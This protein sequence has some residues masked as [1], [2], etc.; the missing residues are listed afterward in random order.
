MIW[1]ISWISILYLMDDLLGPIL[2]IPVN[3]CPVAMQQSA[4]SF[5]KFIW[6]WLQSMIGLT[7][8]AERGKGEEQRLLM[9]NLK[10]TECA[11]ELNY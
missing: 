11:R 4:W 3:C 6:K 5:I 7:S 8:H 9:Q 2:N 1:S 10:A